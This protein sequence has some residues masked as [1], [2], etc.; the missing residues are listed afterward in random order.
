MEQ[1]DITIKNSGATFTTKL[2]NK[3]PSQSQN[4]S[5]WAGEISTCKTSMVSGNMQNRVEGSHRAS[6]GPQN[7]RAPT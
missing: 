1:L 5:K 6:H 4:T 3:I 2:G 7:K